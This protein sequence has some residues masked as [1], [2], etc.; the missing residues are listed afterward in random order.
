MGSLQVETKILV[1]LNFTIDFTGSEDI[2]IENSEE[3]IIENQIQAE[4][5][6]TLAIVKEFPHS[7][8]MWQV[9]WRKVEPPRER[10]ILY[11]AK[12][13]A[14]LKSLIDR[15][16][17]CFKTF[18]IAE[19]SLESIEK[20]IFENTF[21]SFVDPDFPPN[22]ESLYKYTTNFYLP[23]LGLILVNSLTLSCIGGD[24][25]IS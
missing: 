11:N 22:D 8:L 20:M 4:C 25:K 1:E 2:Q 14:Y 18:P 9:N 21:K 12:A 13:N 16:K 3:L 7:K 15:S 6:E 24:H 17:K 19:S 23:N 5:T 10:Q